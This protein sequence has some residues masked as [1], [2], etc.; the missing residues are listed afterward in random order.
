MKIM[1]NICFTKYREVDLSCPQ[2]QENAY[3]VVGG[4]DSQY[5]GS[6]VAAV[7]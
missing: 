6:L 2:A 1:T 7:N 3:V 5:S 4:D